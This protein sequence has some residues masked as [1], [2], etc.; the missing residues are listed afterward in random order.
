[1]HIYIH[2]E[3]SYIITDVRKKMI[4]LIQV[5]EIILTT[6]THSFRNVLNQVRLEK[7]IKIY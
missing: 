7:T 5:T 2:T 3:K 6:Y 1:M 4:I